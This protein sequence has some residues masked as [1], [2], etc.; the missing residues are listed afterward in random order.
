MEPVWGGSAAAATAHPAFPPGFKPEPFVQQAKLQFRRVQEAYD[1]GDREALADVMTP[2][3]FAEISRDLD[4]RAAHTATDVAALDAEIL[5]VVTEG[6]E[7]IAS[8]RFT[9]AMR[10]DGASEAKP[11]VEIWNLAKPVDGS[12]GWLLAGIQQVEESLA[13]R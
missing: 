1:K 7:H 10:E 3:M 9:G 8:V 4:N 6:R 13:G 2:M 12:S 11:F 5:E